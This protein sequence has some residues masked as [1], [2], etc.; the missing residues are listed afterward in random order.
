MALPFLKTDTCIK[1]TLKLRTRDI[2]KV[3]SES[4]YTAHYI[5]FC[6]SKVK[7][8]KP[9]W[10]VMKLYQ[11]EID[12]AR[13]RTWHSSFFWLLNAKSVI[14]FFTHL[15]QNINKLDSGLICYK[16]GLWKTMT[17]YNKFIIIRYDTILEKNLQK[18]ETEK[19]ELG[20]IQSCLKITSRLPIGI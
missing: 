12:S 8:S 13:H 10:F 17:L 2:A 19:S 16:S 3:L 4:V 18:L 7:F 1:V 9:I 15:V 5:H 20:W 6:I 11:G 14:N